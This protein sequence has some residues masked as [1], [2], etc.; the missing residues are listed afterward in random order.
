MK[1][2]T[3]FVNRASLHSCFFAQTYPSSKSDALFKSKWNEA[4]LYFNLNPH[5]RIFFSENDLEKLL[6]VKE[7]NLKLY[8]N[9]DL[10]EILN[11][12]MYEL[13]KFSFVQENKLLRLPKRRFKK[14]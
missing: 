7:R 9:S 2:N 12:S 13:E 11:Y 4:S 8:F 6:Y 3:S 10:D 14:L 5:E 1:S